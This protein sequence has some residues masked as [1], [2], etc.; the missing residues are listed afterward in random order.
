[1]YHEGM[2][3]RMID[4]VPVFQVDGSFFD[5]DAAKKMSLASRT[6]PSHCH[7]PPEVFGGVPEPASISESP[8]LGGLHF[9]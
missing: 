2:L 7:P 3:D 9:S 5:P 6:C 4:E 8:S 1:M